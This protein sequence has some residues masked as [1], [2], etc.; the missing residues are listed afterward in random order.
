M[1]GLAVATILLAA[2]PNAS[3]QINKFSITC[4][5]VGPFAPEPLGDRDG[6]A[7]GVA[8][9]SCYADSGPWSGGVAT[10]T[11]V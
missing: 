2:I 9:Y 1:C 4:Q 6:H 8:N 3:A 5:N 10:A 11:A 7:L